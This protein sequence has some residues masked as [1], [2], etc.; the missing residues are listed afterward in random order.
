MHRDMEQKWNNFGETSPAIF[1]AIAR[2]HQ[3]SADRKIATSSG[4]LSSIIS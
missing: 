1:Y 2:A 3:K 4:A